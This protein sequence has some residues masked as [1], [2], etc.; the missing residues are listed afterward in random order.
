MKGWDFYRHIL[1]VWEV[2]REERTQG[3][4]LLPHS[5][6]SATGAM[7]HLTSSMVLKT[8]IITV[9]FSLET[10]QVYSAPTPRMVRLL[11][12][13]ILQVWKAKREPSAVFSHDIARLVQWSSPISLKTFCGLSSVK[14]AQVWKSLKT[15]SG[16][17]TACGAWTHD[18]RIKS[19]ALYQL[20]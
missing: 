19:P 20:S 4:V 11:Y 3:G 16:S 17:Y 8:F 13:D 15:F 9:W 7:I 14:R 18:H 2:A 5:G 10:F 1:Q 6:G 12:L